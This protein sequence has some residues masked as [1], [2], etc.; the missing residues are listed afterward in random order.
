MKSLGYHTAVFSSSINVAP[1]F[2]FSRGVDDFVGRYMRARPHDPRRSEAGSA[3][4]LK[5]GFYRWLNDS[6]PRFAYLHFME[7]HWPLLPPP[8]FLDMFKGPRSAPAGLYD[9]VRQMENSGHQFSGAEVEEA[10]ADYD[11]DIA[12][13]DSQLGEIWQWMREHDLYD[14]SVII[15]LSDHGEAFFEHGQVWSHGNNVF[16]ETTHVPLIIKLPKSLD[17]KGRISNLVQ[18]VDVFPTVAGL[19]GKTLECDGRDALRFLGQE[20]MDDTFAISRTGWFYHRRTTRRLFPALEE[21]VL[22]PRYEDPKSPAL[23]A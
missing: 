4:P 21:L 13:I 20:P 15:L 1:R 8:P 3:P 22:H 10:R 11:S 16:D 17:V 14:E 18:L 23:S 2:G 7:P 5:E 12:Y 19:F 9:R 6:G